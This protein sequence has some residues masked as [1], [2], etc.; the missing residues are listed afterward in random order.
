MAALSPLEKE[1]ALLNS[2]TPKY[3][4]LYIP[5]SHEKGANRYSDVYTTKE[6]RVQ[7]PLLEKQ[8]GSSYV[9]ATFL[10]NIVPNSK[11]YI[12]ASAPMPEHYLHWWRMIYEHNVG[13]IVML[14]KLSEPSKRLDGT[15]DLKAHE[16]WPPP[17]EVADSLHSYKMTPTQTLTIKRLSTTNKKTFT[18]PFDKS[19]QNMIDLFD[20]TIEES[21]TTKRVILLWNQSLPDHSAPKTPEQFEHYHKFMTLYNTIYKTIPHTESKITRPIL[22]H[23]S[24][25]LGRTGFFIAIDI[26]SDS[27]IKTKPSPFSLIKTFRE[28]RPSMLTDISQYFF[29]HAYLSKYYSSSPESP[30]S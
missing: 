12:A 20:I 17:S 10:E 6:F 16:Y 7:L 8:P 28:R 5:T 2:I 26:L 22:V 9:N 11:R 13:I 3:D 18:D 19:Q 1:F 21:K 24:A 15:F 29:I 27:A 4:T 14:T 23:C 30:S 25:G